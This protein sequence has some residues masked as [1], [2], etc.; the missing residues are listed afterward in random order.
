MRDGIAVF[1]L[2]GR[3]M[4]VNKRILEVGGYSA[5]EIV[6]RSFDQLDMFG[7]QDIAKM[8]S[9]FAPILSGM[10]APP[11]ELEVTTKSGQRLILEVRVSPL[12]KDE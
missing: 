8:A 5:D 9:V 3:L 4:R 7:S 1:D 6:G 10:E 11:L 2:T 12:K